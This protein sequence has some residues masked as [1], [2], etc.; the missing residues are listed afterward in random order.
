MTVNKEKV[1]HDQLHTTINEQ[2]FFS[3]AAKTFC[4]K[5]D[6]NTSSGRRSASCIFFLK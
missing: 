6:W 2:V 1:Q 4:G 5:N 3:A